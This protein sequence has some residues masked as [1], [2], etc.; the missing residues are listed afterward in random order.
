MS[1]DGQAPPE[2]DPDG[3]GDARRSPPYLPYSAAN[4]GMP[5]TSGSSMAPMFRDPPA[6]EPREALWV[7]LRRLGRHRRPS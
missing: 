7:R 3:P 1:S 5:G 6:A 4:M 2:P